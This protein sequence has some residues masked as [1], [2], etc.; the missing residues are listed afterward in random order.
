MNLT[1]AFD[2]KW[3][4]RIAQHK[5]AAWGRIQSEDPALAALVKEC[6]TRFHSTLMHV[7]FRGEVIYGEP[8]HDERVCPLEIIMETSRAQHRERVRELG[9]VICGSDKEVELHHCH[10]GS[11]T[12]AGFRRGL[13]QK[14]SEWL[15]I[16]LHRDYHTGKYNPEVIGVEQWEA[17]FGSQMDHLRAVSEALGYDVIQRARD[18]AREE[19]RGT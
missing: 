12:A 8:P 3:R 6:R 1:D 2:P 18:E 19:D 7:E 17:V 13:G 11:V 5:R 4:E 15:I 16:P 10:G 14:T 9:C